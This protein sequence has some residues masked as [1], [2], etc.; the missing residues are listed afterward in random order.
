MAVGM[1]SNVLIGGI[2]ILPSR[3]LYK[4][5]TDRVGNFSEIQPYFT[6]WK[7]LNIKNGILGIFE[8]EHDSTSSNVPLIPKGTDGRAL[9]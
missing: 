5:L 1:L 4:Y 6:V 2:L 7:S 8:I 9:V 3:S